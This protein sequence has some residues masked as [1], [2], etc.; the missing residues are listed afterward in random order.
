MIETNAPCGMEN[1]TSRSTV[2]RCEPL[3]YSFV[4]SRAMSMIGRAW[5]C[6]LLGAA[7]ACSGAQPD[8]AR[9]P[10]DAGAAVEDTQR[11]AASDDTSRGTVVFFGTSL[12]A[13][14]GVEPEQAYPAIVGAKI[15]SAGLP[16]EAVNLGS[17]GET[18]AGALRR[19]DW[20]L[21]RRP[22]HVL[23]LETGANDG[24]RGLDVDSTRANIQAIV[25]RVRTQLPDTRVLLVQMEAPPNLGADYTRRFREM[26]SELAEANG[27]DLMP[28][29]LDGVAGIDTLNQGDGIHPNPRG[30][31]LIAE[32]VWKSL[33]PLLRR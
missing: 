33:G 18:S 11:T 12:T 9:V 19:I 15:D 22:M 17:S 20:V 16:Y 10:A 31:Q 1:E 25:T 26:Y 32:T 27:V 14:M 2:S 24:L 28:F 4:R 8:E 3:S 21:G 29:L 7:L 5:W 13:G 6:A 23:V 30:H